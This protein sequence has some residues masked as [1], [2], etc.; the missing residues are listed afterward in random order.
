[1]FATCTSVI[2]PNWNGLK[3]LPRCLESLA[4]QTF[5][6]FEIII[7]DNGSTDGSLDYLKENWPDVRLIESG[8]N[9]G[10][11]AANNIGA[12]E[13]Q[14]EWLALLNADAFPEPD[15]LKTLIEATQKYP[16]FSF[17]GS[18]LIQANNPNLLDGTGD[19]YHI[20]GLAWRRDYN[21]PVRDSGGEV[22]EIFSPCAAAAL[23]R[24]DVFLEVGGFDEDFVSYHEDV[25]LG[26]RLRLQGHRALYVPEA[27]VKHIGSSTLGKQSN[28]QVYYGHRNL[29]WSFFQNMPGFLVWKYLPAH[30]LANLIFLIHY[31]MRGQAKA[32]FQSKWDALKGLPKA[33]SKRR[34]IQK[35]RRVKPSEISC[36]MEHGWLKPY[37]LGFRA[38]QKSK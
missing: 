14:G 25:D 33:L 20:S 30:I 18:R 3:H 2:I 36:M 1:M 35:S 22:E 26:F 4:T 38:R 15:W 37:F 31:S 9:K 34:N 28:T 13:A 19:V 16:E 27:I 5:Q 8:E 12:R 6:D 32:I 24:R 11:A 17:F 23:Y 7:V 21:L 10:F 29:V